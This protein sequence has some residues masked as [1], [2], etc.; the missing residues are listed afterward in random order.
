MEMRKFP[1]ILILDLFDNL[2]T[3]DLVKVTPSNEIPL[4]R[5]SRIFN[6]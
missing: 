6:I 1:H 3:I 2:E 5:K 4:G